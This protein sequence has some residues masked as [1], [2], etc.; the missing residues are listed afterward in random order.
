[1]RAL[2]RAL[3]LSLPLFAATTVLAKDVAGSRDHPLVGRYAGSEISQYR[4]SDFDEVRL[5][6]R[7]LDLRR[8]GEASSASAMT[9]PLSAPASKS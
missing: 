7:P 2:V 1:M 5:M 8:D 6:N 4:S 3:S 9:R